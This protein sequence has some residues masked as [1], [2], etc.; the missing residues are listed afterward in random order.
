MR[1][2]PGTENGLLAAA[3]IAFRSS[4]TDSLAGDKSLRYGPSPA[5]M[6]S[7]YIEYYYTFQCS[8]HP[9][10]LIIEGWW[11]QL[12]KSKSGWWIHLFEV[13]FFKLSHRIVA[14]CE[15]HIILCMHNY[16]VSIPCQQTR[17]NKQT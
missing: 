10:D 13:I 17:N 3:Q 5:N 12:R 14:Y 1:V 2:D 6:V 4:G 16:Y 8:V 15:V 7:S 11:S 9:G